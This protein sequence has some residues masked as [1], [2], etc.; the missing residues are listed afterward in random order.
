MMM[1]IRNAVVVGCAAA[2]VF[3]ALPASAQEAAPAAPPPPAMAEEGAHTHDGFFLR[4]GLNAGYS[5]VSQSIEAGGQE[6]EGPTLS[7]F[8]S[9]GFD[10]YLGGTPVDGLVLGG[11]LTTV[12]TSSPTRGAYGGFPEAELD[13]TMLLA[14]VAFFAN[15]YFDPSAGLHLQALLG[16]AAVDFVDAEGQSGGNDPSGPML[17]FGVGYDFW[18]GDE[19]SIGPFG[20]LLY[21]PTSVEV[22][23]ATAK[24]NY[25]YPSIGAAFTYH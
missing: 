22:L 1:G 6:A 15:Y 20:R 13:G 14:G 17:G 12:T 24:A 3:V 10:L 11:M 9:W 25:V 18:I 7:G 21:A 2:A 19:W 16:Y 4:L 5:S 8:P 23:G